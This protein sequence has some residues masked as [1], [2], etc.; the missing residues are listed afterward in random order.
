M[1][2]RG[3]TYQALIP[4]NGDLANH[5]PFSYAMPLGSGD[6]HLFCLPDVGALKVPG[7]LKRPFDGS[8]QADAARWGRERYRV[9]EALS[10]APV[11]GEAFPINVD[12]STMRYH[13]VDH[14]RLMAR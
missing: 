1:S 9:G 12:G 14:I 8:I 4:A 3:T 5:L 10:L 7:Q 11:G 6:F 13:A 2:E